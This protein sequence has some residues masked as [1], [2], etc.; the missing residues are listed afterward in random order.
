MPKKKAPPPP[1]PEP[2]PNCLLWAT[3]NRRRHASKA[4]VASEEA[5]FGHLAVQAA[6]TGAAIDP[7]LTGRFSPRASSRA[8]CCEKDSGVAGQARP[9]RRRNPDLA[10]LQALRAMTTPMT[11]PARPPVAYLPARPC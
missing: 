3:E 9:V 7:S 5:R 6:R 4:E 11:T 1:E 2:E 8:R 10:A